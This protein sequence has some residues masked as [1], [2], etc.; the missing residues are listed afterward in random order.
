LNG[1]TNE[2]S[3]EEKIEVADVQALSLEPGRRLRT[4]TAGVFLF[5]PLLAQL[6]FDQVVSAADYPGSKMVPACNALL[7]LLALKL[8]DK[9]RR[10]H[11][12]DFNCDAA[13]G[14]WAGL[15]ILP[16]K[17][18][19][20]DY[21][22]RTQRC[23]QEKLLQGWIAKLSP[24]LFPD[25]KSF[26]LDFHAIP[27]RG[28]ETDL[29]NHYLPMRGKAGPSILSFFAQEQKSRVLC[30]ANANLTRDDQP[31]EVLQFVEFWRALTGKNP[32][33]LYFDSRLTTYAEL[34]QLTKHEIWFVTIRRRGTG[35]L[36]RLA[37]LS[38]ATWQ[39]AVI[40]IPKR[41][42]QQI[43]YVDEQVALPEYAGK[44]RQVAVKGLG[45]EQPTLFL[46]NNF[47]STPRDLIT[48]YAR[49]NGVE[50]ALGSS[51]NFFHLDCL[52]SEVRLNVDLDTVLTVLA[53][54]CYRWLASQLRGLATRSPKGSI[55]NSS[56]HP[57]PSRSKPG[58]GSWCTSTAARTTR[59]SARPNWKRNVRPSPG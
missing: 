33:W 6:R 27:H 34:S 35:L 1:N 38:E 30:Y 49:R 8:L 57:A 39:K 11:I 7:S 47:T 23:H 46:S 54:G 59:Y 40:D 4:R 17:S 24:L 9:E 3:D 14:L 44:A 25:A 19:A 43:R 12:D 2:S 32:Q 10:S 45:R 15:N 5:W 26:S 21:S 29:E 31:G 37:A 48:N 28:E 55:A 50:D 53:Q 42:H 36:R 52:A 18:F 16:K 41:R 58:D 20:T 22:Y 51:V 56:R 13:L